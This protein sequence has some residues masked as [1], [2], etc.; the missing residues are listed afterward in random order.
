[1]RKLV[2]ACLIISLSSCKFAEKEIYIMPVNYTGNIYIFSNVKNGESKQ[3]DD[4]HSRVYA[5]PKSGILLSQFKEIYGVINKKFVYKAKNGKQ[6]EFEGIP[7]QNDKG[8]LDNNKVYAFYGNDATITFPK[9]KDTIGIQIVTIC[10][11]KD[12]DITNREPFL[13]II[14]GSNFLLQDVNYQKLIE[15]RSKY[16]KTN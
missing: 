13:K 10:K 14:S 16:D 3:Y 2:I 8:S 1:M 12:F 7:F 11:P 6:I 5:V 15:M 9:A 4:K